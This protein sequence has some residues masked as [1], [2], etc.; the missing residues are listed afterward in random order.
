MGHLLFL[1]SEQPGR[2]FHLAAV[3]EL[4][5]VAGVVRVIPLVTLARGP[6][7]HVGTIRAELARAGIRSEVR[8]VGY[9]FQRGGNRMLRIE[10]HAP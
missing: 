6:S 3:R 4:L 5:R 10:G 9:G 2:G 8:R 1:Y 7:P